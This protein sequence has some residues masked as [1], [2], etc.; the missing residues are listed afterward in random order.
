MKEETYKHICSVI[1]NSIQD[2]NKYLSIKNNISKIEY[3][4]FFQL[5]NKCWSGPNEINLGEVAFHGVYIFVGK[6]T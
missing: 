6:N 1:N 5:E 4:T 2:F 3:N